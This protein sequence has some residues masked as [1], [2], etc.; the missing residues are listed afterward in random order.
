MCLPRVE[1]EN[2][3][4]KKDVI[5]FRHGT[6]CSDFIVKFGAATWITSIAYSEGCGAGGKCIRVKYT[7]MM[8]VEVFVENMI[9]DITK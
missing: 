2:K 8:K 4:R 1:P 6:I 3:P 7:P 5:V 9:S